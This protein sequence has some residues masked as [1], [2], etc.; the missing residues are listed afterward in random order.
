MEPAVQYLRNFRD[1]VLLKSRFQH[2]F[3]RLL[4]LYYRVGRPVADVMNRNRALKYAI[5]YGLIWPVVAGLKIGT[6]V[7]SGVSRKSRT[8]AP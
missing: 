6:R 1:N 8:K 5:R 2:A 4:R 7:M 3:E